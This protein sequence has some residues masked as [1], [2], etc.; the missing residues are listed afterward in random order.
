MLFE[1]SVHLH[2]RCVA[3]FVLML[4]SLRAQSSDARRIAK[5]IMML[6]QPSAVVLSSAVHSDVRTPTQDKGRA[7]SYPLGVLVNYWEKRIGSPS[8]SRSVPVL[9]SWT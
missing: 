9:G 1:D 6:A 4:V 5:F 7:L 2:D 8:G 3:G